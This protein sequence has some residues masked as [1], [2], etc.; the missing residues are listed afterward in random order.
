MCLIVFIRVRNRKSAENYPCGIR[1]WLRQHFAN[2][3]NSHCNRHR[4]PPSYEEANGSIE[5]ETEDP[6]AKDAQVRRSGFWDKRTIDICNLPG[7]AWFDFA[8]KLFASTSMTL[9]CWILIQPHKSRTK[10]NLEVQKWW[11]PRLESASLASRYKNIFSSFDL[12]LMATVNGVIFAYHDSSRS[13][14]LGWSRA[15][16]TFFFS[17]SRR[18]GFGIQARKSNTR[19]FSSKGYVNF[20]MHAGVT[21]LESALVL[22]VRINNSSIATDVSSA[23][24]GR[25]NIIV[26]W[27][28]YTSWVTFHHLPEAYRE[29]QEIRRE[30]MTLGTAQPWSI[31]KPCDL[32]FR[33][34]MQ[35]DPFLTQCIVVQARLPMQMALSHLNLPTPLLIP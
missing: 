21:F 10:V 3:K 20:W 5:R 8:A 15:R 7:C 18:L 14:N 32:D 4:K 26:S 19:K 22:R 11:I 1:L 24:L 17:K 30:Y 31:R 33:I 9:Q 16:L 27:C 28:F 13:R 6:T 25:W 34:H 35:N 12:N 29:F 23:R 2:G